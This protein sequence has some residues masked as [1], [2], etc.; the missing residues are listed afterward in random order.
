MQLDGPVA[1]AIAESHANDRLAYAA[2]GDTGRVMARRSGRF[3][4]A[5]RRFMVVF[6]AGP[7]A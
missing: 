6:R 5:A 3:L 1:L 7:G 4:L 2:L